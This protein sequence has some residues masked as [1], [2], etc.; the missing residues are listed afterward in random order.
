VL[1]EK[2]G[3]GKEKDHSAER[4]R[5]RRRR[6][7]WGEGAKGAAANR[8][9]G[10]EKKKNV[11]GKE[12]GAKK[13]PDSRCA[14]RPW[15][16]ITKS[17]KGGEESARERGVASTV[18]ER[19]K[20]EEERQKTRIGRRLRRK[21]SCCIHKRKSESD[22]ERAILLSSEKRRVRIGHRKK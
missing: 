12:K 1:L 13:E 21:N 6:S 2:K 11:A 19:V 20:N 8:L 15:L 5:G 18:L 3:G 22:G 14:E 4:E 17:R 7:Y 10:E 16:A 9:Q